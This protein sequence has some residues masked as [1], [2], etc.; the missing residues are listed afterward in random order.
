LPERC[1]SASQLRVTEPLKFQIP[2]Q[3]KPILKWAGGKGQ[4]LDEIEKR[5]PPNFNR[6]VE[7][8][9]GGGAVFFYLAHRL[10]EGAVISDSNPELVN[11]Y[12]QV[13]AHVEDVIA[14]LKT[15]KNTEAEFYKIRK[16]DYNKLP[17]AEAAARTIYLNRT[18]FNGLYR[19]NKKGGFNVPFGNYANP[20]ICNEEALY[21]A[22]QAL[23]KAT[24]LC[25]DYKLVLNEF[26]KSGDLVFLDPPYLPIS[27]YADFKRYTKEQF[28][29]EDHVEL[30][31]AAKAANNR[32]AHI[33]LTNSNH[34]LVHELYDDYEL[35][36]I[37][38][39]RNINKDATKRKGEDVIVNMPV[40]PAPQ[41]SEIIPQQIQLY[42]GTK[43]MGS[44]EKLI[45]HIHRL[46][47][48]LQFDTVVD[49]FSGSGVVSYL[50]K[51]LG[52]RV[53]SNDFLNMSS[54]FTA[55]LIENHQTRVSKEEAT[56]LTN[57]DVQ[58][59]S[60][61]EDNYTGIFFNKSE[62]QALDAIRHNIKNLHNP[63][64]RA[65]AMTALI[66]TCMKKQAR[67]I[68]TYVGKRYDDGR[69]DLKLGITQHFLE[70]LEDVNKAVFSNGKSNRS[71]NGDAME[72]PIH[73]LDN[74]RALIYIDPPY[75]TP[76]SDSDYVRRYHFVE[77]LSKNWDGLEI[78]HTSKVKKF[79]SYPTPFSTRTGAHDAFDN[80]FKKFRQHIIVVSYS[81]NSL[82]SKDELTSLLAKYKT[83][84]EVHEL[85]YRYHFGNQNKRVGNNRNKVKE[86]LFIAS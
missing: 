27:Q 77:G 1:V 84:V 43:F 16:L 46:T 37:S 9:I 48:H 83:T 68:F 33:I 81:S 11:L 69:R 72:F 32:G 44:K 80:L 74:S 30:A 54:T 50:Y 49:L 29:D 62:N 85:D 18:C 19:V 73:C 67:G 38:T 82:P 71:I 23:S 8:F 14:I 24:I 59:D 12:Q 17:K 6:L 63:H 7:P 66:R 51:S 60:F 31:A 41:I 21:A 15:R 35:S 52:K 47:S 5:L 75:F 39:K 64:K 61:I 53:I 34:P 28:Y 22:S 20:N 4:L 25:A 78:Q 10:K 13:A 76:K 86:Y 58:C 70:A 42:P 3:A 36:I 26:T 40:V 55:A 2:T 56:A 45:P 79:K 57:L 65:I